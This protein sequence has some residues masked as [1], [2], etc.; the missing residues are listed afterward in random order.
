MRQVYKDIVPTYIH[1]NFANFSGIEDWYVSYNKPGS[2]MD[3]LEKNDIQE[4]WILF[5]GMYS[6]SRARLFVLCIIPFFFFCTRP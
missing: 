5:M 2:A 1:P 6:S 4:E 3:W